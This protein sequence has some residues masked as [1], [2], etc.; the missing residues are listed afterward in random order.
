M[1]KRAAVKE[2]GGDTELYDRM[3]AQYRKQLAGMA[4]KGAGIARMRRR[5][6]GKGS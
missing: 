6:K 5:L 2:R 3:I 4:R 1:V